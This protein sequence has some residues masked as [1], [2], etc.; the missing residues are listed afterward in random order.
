METR[1]KG[2]VLVSRRAFVVR[3]FGE[4]AWERV[5][6]ALA[7]DDRRHLAPPAPVGWYPFPLGE[8]LDRAIV[9]VLGDGDAEVFRRLGAASARE[10]L[11]GSHRFFLRPGDPQGFL[12]RTE[13][14]YHLYYDHGRR[15]YER[16][17]P[18]SGVLTTYD[19]EIFST[20]DCL[21]VAGFYQEALAMC[22]AR[23][24]E[25]VEET[26]RARGGAHCRYRLSWRLGESDDNDPTDQETT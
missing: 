24:V 25:V 11:T 23:E 20:P 5:L 6:A 13:S 4:D 1:V 12:E 15:S 10:N 19:A 26:C 21:T 3:H 16:T 17:G 14:F 18:T 7:P 2:S 8:R 9:A 22:G